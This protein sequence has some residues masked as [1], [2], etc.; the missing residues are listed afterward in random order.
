MPPPVEYSFDYAGKVETFS[1][2]AWTSSFLV[3]VWGAGGGG[4]FG[5]GGT[6]GGAGGA[7]G[8][9]LAVVSGFPEGA[10]FSVTVGGSRSSRDSTRPCSAGSD[11][12]VNPSQ[13][14]YKLAE[15]TVFGGGG[16]GGGIDSQRR[17][18]DG[19]GG[20]WIKMGDEWLV[21]AGGGGGGNGRWSTN[22]GPTPA[23]QGG[24]GGG[25]SGEGGAGQGSP[26]EGGTQS[27]GGKV[28]S[29]L[30]V[31]SAC[32][33][34][35]AGEKGFGGWATGGTAPRDVSYGAGGGGG[36]GY[37]GG[38]GG[39]GGK[40][41]NDPQSGAGGSGYINPSYG[42]G[43]T[44]KSTSRKSPANKDNEHYVTGIAYGGEAGSS[45][46]NNRAGGSGLVVIT[47]DSTPW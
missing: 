36:G 43:T 1:A 13:G 23:R 7:G 47:W 34:V 28:G 24:G 8:A 19:G 25:T 15:H 6:T 40:Q 10:T 20:S 14:L 5:Q 35:T 27:A 41:N 9:T 12:C 26:P 38:G 22:N 44:W 31:C 37:Y 32:T 17:G 21:A 29:G 33:A 11:T 39:D 4:G 45:A 2:P 30:N 18:G 46:G 3:K 16:L 42:K